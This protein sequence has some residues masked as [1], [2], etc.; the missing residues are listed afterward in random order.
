MNFR[1]IALLLL[2]FPAFSQQTMQLSADRSGKADY[3]KQKDA[4]LGIVVYKKGD[5]SVATILPREYFILGDYN[6]TLELRIKPS[7]SGQGVKYTAE[8]TNCTSIRFRQVSE[9]GSERFVLSDGE[10]F[11]AFDISYEQSPANMHHAPA[12]TSLPPDKEVGYIRLRNTIY[13]YAQIPGTKVNLAIIDMNHNGRADTA[14]FVSLSGDE[15]FYSAERSYARKLSKVKTIR[16]NDSWYRFMLTDPALFRFTL[17]EMPAGKAPDICYTDQVPD[18]DIAGSSLYKKLDSAGLVIL[19]HWT[20]YSP[21]STSSLPD[22]NDLAFEYPVI[23]IHSGSELK[24]VLDRFPLD[25][26]NVQATDELGSALVFHGYP[27]FMVV[28]RSKKIVVD[29]SDLEA[30]KEF[31]E[32]K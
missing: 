7:K 20:E 29:T 32:G 24:A 25:F 19:T 11:V 1:A 23:G 30:V 4:D 8:C 16:I 31:L 15:F 22:M 10:D 6:D 18:I 21:Q 9:N 27:H 3:R 12:E 13:R 5:E 2:S 28:D 17:T 14:D 26:P